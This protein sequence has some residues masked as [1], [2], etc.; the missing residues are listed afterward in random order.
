MNAS[1]SPAAPHTNKTV[2][3]NYMRSILVQLAGIFGIIS[4]APALAT[5]T[6][7]G[8]IPKAHYSISVPAQLVMSSA[9]VGGVLASFESPAVTTGNTAAC[10]YR[11]L[12]TTTLDTRGLEPSGI[13]NVYKTNIEGV[14][15]RITGWSNN[16]LYFTPPSQTTT[17]PVIPGN[18]VYPTH[19]KVE[20]V[21]I[22]TRIGVSGP[23]TT[24]FRVEHKIPQDTT[25]TPEVVSFESTAKTTQLINE[26]YFSSCESQTPILN[27]P[28]GV[29]HIHKISTNTAPKKSFSFEVRCQGM[30]PSKPVPVKIYFEGDS[31][32]EGLLNLS[33]HGREGVARGIHIALTTSDGRKLPFSKQHPINLDW[34]RSEANAEVYRVS[35]EAQYVQ[36]LTE[37]LKPGQAD[38]TMTYVLEYN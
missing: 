23:V 21:R 18:V 2:E 6:P 36:S 3:N 28:M 11:T 25:N 31:P 19:I 32:A 33:G 29:Q 7:H 20:Y 4:S 24:D 22:G 37:V 38:A 34:L 1:N 8:T 13:P 15:I 10:S 35:G 30:K 14:G 9:P 12:I 5:C 17:G 26:V 16:R 27:V